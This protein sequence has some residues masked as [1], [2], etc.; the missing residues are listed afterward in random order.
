MKTK[1]VEHLAGNA[2]S[3]ILEARG[4]ADSMIS[5]YPEFRDHLKGAG[6][7]LQCL[8]EKLEEA[9]KYIELLT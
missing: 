5:T 7:D 2:R 4:E 9:L 1:I 8:R 3:A 6:L